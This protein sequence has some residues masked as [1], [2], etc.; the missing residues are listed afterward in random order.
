V[1]NK[2]RLDAIPPKDLQRV[3]ETALGDIQ[4]AQGS[5]K[6]SAS[7]RPVFHRVALVRPTQAQSEKRALSDAASALAQLWKISPH[8][9]R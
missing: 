5:G 8:P 9:A 2:P 4:D 7:R 1:T 6:P 3:F